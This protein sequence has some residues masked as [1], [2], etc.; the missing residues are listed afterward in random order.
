METAEIAFD[1]ALCAEFTFESSV[2]VT[3]A[4]PAAVALIRFERAFKTLCIPFVETPPTDRT[5]RVW[6]L[7]TRPSTETICAEIET[8]L[9]DK[10]E[11][12]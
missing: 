4:T 1:K 6:R 11:W 10:T 12:S 9:S 3:L 2:L 8:T 5:E 7:V